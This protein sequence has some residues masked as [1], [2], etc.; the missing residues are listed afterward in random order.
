MYSH[1][2][3]RGKIGKVETRNRVVMPGMLTLLADPYG[4]VDDALVKYY[5]ERAKGGIGLIIAEYANIDFETGRAAPSQLTMLD[6]NSALSIQKIAR[7]VHRHGAKFFAQLAHAGQGA[8][9]L[10]LD[11]KDPIGPSE[12]TT[13]D[14]RR[15][16][17]MTVEEIQTL[18]DRFVQGAVYAQIGE[19]DG[20]EIHAA[21]IYLLSTFLS[22]HLNRRDDAYGGSHENR[23]RVICEIIRGI[24]E[25]CGKDFPVSVRI[26]GSDFVEGGTTLE[27]AVIT[28]KLLE[29][30]GADALNISNSTFGA[31]K[32]V[33]EPVFF[34][35]GWKKH[36]AK[37]IKAAVQIPII[38]VNTIKTPEFAE[39][40]LEE[41]VS[42]FVGLARQSLADPYWCK[43]AMAGEEDLIHHC[44]SCLY[45]A[46][47]ESK[48][49]V[50]SCAVNPKTGR[51]SELAPLK[52]DG[53]GR[54]VVVIGGGVAGMEA[55]SVLGQRGFKVTLFEQKDHLGGDTF[56]AGQPPMKD[57]THQLPEVL[58]R[59]CDK[60]GVTIHLNHAPTVDE[61]KALNPYAVFV[62]TGADPVIPK[63]IPG[64]ESD[65]I[66][67]VGQI[68]DQEV[69]LSGKKIV[70][71]G[72]GLSGLDV[73]SFLAENNDVQVVEMQKAIGIGVLPTYIKPELDHL[74]EKNVALHTS[75]A[76]QSIQEKTVIIEDLKTGKVFDLEAD[77]VI[78]SLGVRPNN[79][80]IQTIQDNFENVRV[81]GSAVATTGRI[82]Q[83]MRDGFD[84]AYALD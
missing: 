37:T 43:K 44:I 74:K 50:V 5:E 28:A 57:W 16:R 83:A 26:N 84:A 38:A 9:P 48:F 65:H 73:A 45:C 21:H 35:Q 59:E 15:V 64:I 14:G 10:L 30:A 24:K 13:P 27:D 51:E 18:I 58:K 6:L 17:A 68:L 56:L 75:S 71:I 29:A 31:E 47:C 55:A 32:P 80:K 4:R 46:D 60:Y 42:D 63:K 40:L 39:S 8:N 7:V 70:V 66:Y 67:T 23:A 3:S 25:K 77:A 1:L 62:A 19:A 54:Q 22:P 72:G 61:I 78:L 20:V 82:G 76:L 33:I 79:E 12:S 11:G 69:A 41:G 34:G 52:I 2:F 36:L 81:I 53:Q 49:K